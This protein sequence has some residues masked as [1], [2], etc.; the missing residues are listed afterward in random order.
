[1]CQDPCRGRSPLIPHQPGS[2]SQSDHD[3]MSVKQKHN[4]LILR[5]K[6]NIPNI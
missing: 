2:S 5:L 6:N 4:H 3:R 1:M